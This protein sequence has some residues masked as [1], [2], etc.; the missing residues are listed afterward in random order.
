MSRENRL[1]DSNQGANACQMREVPH[2]RSDQHEITVPD[3]WNHGYTSQE[4]A[5]DAQL[6]LAISRAP[7]LLRKLFS[8]RTEPEACEV[9]RNII[10][11]FTGDKKTYNNLMTPFNRFIQTK[12]AD[13]LLTLYTKHMTLCGIFQMENNAY[14]TLLY[15]YLRTIVNRAFGPG[16]TF[17]GM[18][19]SDST[20]YQ[21]T[22][23]EYLWAKQNNEYVLETRA[24]QS[25][26]KD[27][28]IA[29]G[30][31]AAYRPE[32]QPSF[33]IL[34]HYTFPVRCTTALDVQDI[35]QYPDE[36]EIL[37]SPL[38][39]F[40]VT[41]IEMISSDYYIISLLNVPV[42]RMPL[43]QLWKKMKNSS[44]SSFG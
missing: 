15:L 12:K 3:D 8:L 6:V 13:H 24:F 20:I 43:R 19:I 9:I 4:N 1:V 28:A 10:R 14:T 33:A 23:N 36:E 40:K 37:I 39:L 27:R 26:S 21:A 11:R 18:V 16:E 5:I 7:R 41:K 34:C 22:I 44:R 2:T 38:T 17:R 29:E 31:I 30:Y 32:N 35:S 25:T 42:P